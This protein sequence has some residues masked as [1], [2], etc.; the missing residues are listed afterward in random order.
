MLNTIIIIINFCQR[1]GHTE[2][3]D[4]GRAPQEGRQEDHL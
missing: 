2:G 4:C 3:E 1:H